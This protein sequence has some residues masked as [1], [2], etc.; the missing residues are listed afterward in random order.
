MNATIEWNQESQTFHLTNDWLSYVIQID[1]LGKLLQLYFGKPVPLQVDYRYLVEHAN[2]P[3]AVSEKKESILYS[4]EHLKQEF[5]ERGSSDYRQIAIEICQENGSQSSDFQYLKHKIFPGKPTIPGLPASYL[6]DDSEGQTLQIHCYDQVMQAEIILSYTLFSRQAIITR[7]VSIHNKGKQTL[8]IE[9]LM[10]LNLDLPDSCYQMLQ[11]DGA[12]G[13][14][15][16]LNQRELSPGIQSIASNR[17][18]SSHN[19]NP[20]LALK[21]TETTEFS[22]EAIGV[23]FVYSGDF[24]AQVQVDTYQTTR[25]QMG[26]NSETFSWQLKPE[27][28]FYSPEAVLIYSSNGLNAMSQQFHQFANQH[29]VRG[30]WKQKERPVLLNNWEATYF[31]FTEEKLR[32]LATEAQDLGVEL[33]VLD[34]GWFG[35]RNSD[36]QGLG[37][38]W[39]NQKKLPSGLA[40]LAK[41]VNQLGLQF[42]VWIEPE[43]VNSDSDFYRKHPDWAFHL[44]Q[45]RQREGRNQ[46]VLNF[47]RPEVVEA[48]YQQLTQ[49][50]KDANIRYVK[51]DM[52]RSHSE[53]FDALKTKEQQ[54]ELNHRYLLGVYELY[55][56]LRSDFPEILF[57][58]C[59][60]GGGRFDLGMLYYAPQTWASDCSDAVERL[61]IQ[62]GTSFIYPLSS[63]GAHVSIVPNHQTNRKTS[64]QMRNDVAMFGVYGYELDLAALSVKEKQQIK[65]NIQLYKQY[66]RVFQFGNFYRLLSPFDS[67]ETA[68]MVVSEDEKTVIVGWYQVLNE[69][70][71]PYKRLYLTGLDKNGDYFWVNQPEKDIKKKSYSGAELMHAGWVTTTAAAGQYHPELNLAESTDFMSKIVIFEKE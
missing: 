1:S 31:D 61:K 40:G 43:M 36:H 52:N 9:R 12:W 34:D 7:N 48:V 35:K 26:M 64:L 45:R 33:F 22:G 38:W 14:E 65:K 60:S 10:A 50:F 70:N 56:R 44:P 18:H 29:L 15:R 57:E 3:M 5:P 47:S 58:S 2:R 17:G 32:Q 51:W 42:G 62:Y 49:T 16:H 39:V 67:N 20:F 28:I 69:V 53:V 24:L 71:G 27:E 8:Q 23:A 63:I 4:Y 46:L 41:E 21:R 66:R 6:E 68:W 19:H 55:E 59:A 13:R 37:D 30:P 54:K 11:L 25:L